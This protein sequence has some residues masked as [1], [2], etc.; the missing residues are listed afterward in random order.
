MCLL[1]K[2]PSSDLLVAPG[3]R[4]TDRKFPGACWRDSLAE[5]VSSRFCERAC[6]KNY[7]TY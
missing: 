3:L 6:L 2:D 4:G 7:E 5:S 1:P